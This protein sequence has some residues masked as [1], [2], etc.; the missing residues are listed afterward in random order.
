MKI[1]QKTNKKK[2]LKIKKLFL[3][4]VLP[5]TFLLNKI[6]RFV[7]RIL[8]VLGLIPENQ[9][10]YSLDTSLPLVDV[11]LDLLAEFSNYF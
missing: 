9:F 11:V 10:G 8:Y 7:S 3:S 6:S 5:L 4:D 2:I 1:K